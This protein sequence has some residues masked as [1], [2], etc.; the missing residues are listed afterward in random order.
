MIRRKKTTMFIDAKE[1]TTVAE[2]KRMIEGITKTPPNQQR[3]FNRDAVVMDDDKTLS[4]CGLTSTLAKAQS[5]AEIALACMAEH[6]VWEDAEKTPY[7]NP[8][9]LPDVMKPGGNPAGF[10]A[11]GGGG[12]ATA[13]A[14][15]SESAQQEN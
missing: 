7:S 15:A 2:L 14:A 1:N 8:P 3:L 9:E 12:G 13:A 5:P 10:G 6:G 4:D 11:G